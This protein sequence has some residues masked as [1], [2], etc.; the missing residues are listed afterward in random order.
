M[1]SY[2]CVVKTFRYKSVK[3]DSEEGGRDEVTQPRRRCEERGK[4]LAHTYSHA[5]MHSGNTASVTIH[6]RGKQTH[7][8]SDSDEEGVGETPD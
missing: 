1:F 2:L 5:Q 6:P 7:S 8:P 4:P 3:E